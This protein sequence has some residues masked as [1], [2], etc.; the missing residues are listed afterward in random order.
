[1]PLINFKVELSLT[2]DPNCVLCTSAG[3]PTFTI[4]DAKLYVAIVTLSTEDNAK[5]SK[6]LR[7]GF[8]K[9]VYWNTCKVIAEKSYDANA[10]IRES[11]DSSCQGIN[12]LFVL[13]YK[14]VL[15]ELQSILTEDTFFQE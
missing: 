13:A 1:M 10:T 14:V 9:P 3:A 6:G 15:I 7:E 12:R 2:W 11:T 5:L 4:T 8:K